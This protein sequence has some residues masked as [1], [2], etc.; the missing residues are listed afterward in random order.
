MLQN[1][2]NFVPTLICISTCLHLCPPQPLPKICVYSHQWHLS[3]H[4]KWMAKCAAHSSVYREDFIFTLSVRATPECVCYPFLVCSHISS[5]PFVH[6]TWD[7]PL[8]QLVTW[9]P[10]DSH[11]YHYREG[12]LVQLQW[13]ITERS[14][15]PTHAAYSCP[16]V[17]LRLDQGYTISVL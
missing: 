7:F 8:F 14:R 9:D 3:F 1:P 16:M 5:N 6:Q 2:S 11:R 13:V 17:Q 12:A 15:L 10:V 4:T